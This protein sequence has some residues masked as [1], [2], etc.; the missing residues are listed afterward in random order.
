MNTERRRGRKLKHAKRAVVDF[1]EGLLNDDNAPLDILNA[2]YKRNIK[3]ANI[4]I[5]NY[6]GTSCKKTKTQI[7]NNLV[8]IFGDSLIGVISS[9]NN[10][11]LLTVRYSP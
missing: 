3:T 8:I 9:I 1:P 2:G 10:N 4:S 11:N 5:L 6:V 7:F